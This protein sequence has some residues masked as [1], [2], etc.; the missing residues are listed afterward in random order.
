MSDPRDEIEGHL[1]T[2]SAWERD[3]GTRF[4]G[5]A[6][7][8]STG[9]SNAAI[10]DIKRLLDE[11]GARYHWRSSS[12]EYVLDSIDDPPGSEGEPE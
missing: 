11:L 5:D 3:Y 4:S 8:K 9:E 10:A 12:G 2:L 7:L 6:E 1:R